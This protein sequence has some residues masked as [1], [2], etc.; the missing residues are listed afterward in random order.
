MI[1]L[2]ASMGGVGCGMNPCSLPMQHKYTSIAEVQ[3][4]MEDEYLRSPLSGVS[5]GMR[6]GQSSQAGSW[7]HSVLPGVLA[8]GGAGGLLCWEGRSDFSGAGSGVCGEALGR[9]WG[10]LPLGSGSLGL[11]QAHCAGGSSWYEVFWSL[12][13]PG[14][15]R[16]GASPCGNPVPGPSAKPAA[17]HGELGSTG[18]SSWGLPPLLCP[19]PVMPP[20]V[21]SCIY[22]HVTPSCSGEGGL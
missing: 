18:P 22:F 13:A 19:F 5:V 9:S 21:S 14:G 8:V 7:G 2:V 12:L 11:S 20:K 6:M 16:S 3:V 1:G 17:I 15:R 10:Y 4:H